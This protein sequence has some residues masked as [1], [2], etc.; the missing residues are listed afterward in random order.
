MNLEKELMFLE[1]EAPELNGSARD[2]I[3]GV[4]VG[5][6]IVAGIAGIVALT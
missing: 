3:E 2:F 4:G 5:I 1:V 6:G